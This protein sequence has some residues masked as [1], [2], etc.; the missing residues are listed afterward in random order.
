MKNR[1]KFP[2]IKPKPCMGLAMHVISG[3]VMETL[4][5]LSLSDNHNRIMRS[6]RDA[7]PTHY[8]FKI[9]TFSAF[10]KNS[11]DKHE[12][13]EFEAGGYQWKLALHPN[14][15]KSKE[16]KDHISLY[17]VIAQTSS[18]P[19]AW[20]INVIFRLFVFDHIQD[21]YLTV[22]DANGGVR[23]FHASKTEW[24]FD[25]FIPISVF[26]DP[27]RGYLVDDTCV[28]GA[29][30][31]VIKSA[32]QGER[33]S[34]IKNATAHKH[35]WK[36]H[37][38]Y[39]RTESYT[40]E[41]FIAGDYKWN[42]VLYPRGSGNSRGLCLSMYLYLADLTTLTSNQ[43]VYV[44]YCLRLIDQI[45]KEPVEKKVTRWYSTASNNWGWHDFLLLRDLNNPEKGYL[46][47]DSCIIEAEVNVLGIVDK[48]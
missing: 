29:E 37:Y 11:I 14:G 1:I 33:L 23:R 40:S 48:F 12:S 20:E 2:L 32:G 28:F 45:Q 5:N 44:H 16:E 47:N 15:N 43:K 13:L 4:V 31:F 17:L 26:N 38:F 18:L 21:K 42:V 46:L 9:Q 10:S 39:P 3:E 7:P 6:F 24:G 27:T 8:T 19:S 34:M 36:I 35:T 41:I 25:Q 22:Q 30:V